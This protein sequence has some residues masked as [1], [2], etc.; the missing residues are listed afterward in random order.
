ME[1]GWDL[2]RTQMFA[3]I[4]EGHEKMPILFCLFLVLLV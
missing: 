3:K 4:T 1:C 2:R